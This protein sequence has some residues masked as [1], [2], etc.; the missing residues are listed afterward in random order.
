MPQGRKMD[1][2]VR[3]RLGIEGLPDAF[4]ADD[5]GSIPFTRSKLSDAQ[6]LLPGPSGQAQPAPADKRC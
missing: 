3:T 1:A 2:S 4:Q 5:E 6:P